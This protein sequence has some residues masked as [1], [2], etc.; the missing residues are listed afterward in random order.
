MTASSFAQTDLDALRYSRL[1]TIGS[2]RT[3]AVG[4]AFGALGGDFTVLSTN[5]AG[6]ATYRHSEISLSGSLAL[7]QTV[8]DFAGE[9]NSLLEPYPNLS[10]VGIIL[11]SVNSTRGSKWKTTNFALGTNRLANFNQRFNFSGTTEGTI[12]DRYL[13]LADG[14]E[15]DNLGLE[16]RMAY[17]AY[18]IDNVSGSTTE[19]FADADSNSMV[20][21]NQNFESNGYLNEFVI[22]YGANYMHRLYIGATLGIP[23]L[24]YSEQRIY[25]EEDQDNSID[26]FN[27]MSYTEHLLTDGLGVNLKIGAILRVSQSIRLGAAI[28]TPTAMSLTDRYSSSMTSSITFNSVDGPA[29]FAEASGASVYEYSLNTPWRLVAS[30]AYIFGK[31]GFISGEVE[32]LDYGYANFNFNTEDQNDLDYLNELNSSV[33]NKYGQAINL[34]VGAEMVFDKFRLRG[35]YALYGSPFN[36]GVAFYDSV[37]GNISVGAGYHSKGFFADLAFV[38]SSRTEEYVPYSLQ[39][40]T[41]PSAINDMTF[42]QLVLTL[43]FKFY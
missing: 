24:K 1:Q 27:S 20:F 14:I 38:Q 8:S 29:G 10:N 2:G 43:G 9:S 12:T 21:K 6:I 36:D 40:G 3:M 22:A 5:P 13:E 32:Y 26:Y 39:N 7:N 34:K 30:G 4:G 18:L 37:I 17:D 42:A 31:K 35:G 19:Y 33:T 25:N 41:A 15:A 11:S 23:F 16:S 28:H